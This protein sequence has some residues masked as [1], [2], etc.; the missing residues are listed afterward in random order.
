MTKDG[1]IA[2]MHKQFKI[3]QYQTGET[4]NTIPLETTI[5]MTPEMAA[6][7]TKLKATWEAGDFGHFATY[8]L[9]GEME[10]LSRFKIKPGMH[11]LD[12]ACGAGQTAIPMA[13]AGANVTGIDIASNLIEQARARAKAENVSVRFDEGDAENL[14]YEDNS[15]DVVFSSFGAM[16]APRPDLVAAELKRVCK[17]GGSIIMIN[18]TP[19]GFIGKMFKLSGQHVP[20]SPLMVPPVKWGDEETVRARF[21]DGIAD[22]KL[23]QR[24]FQFQYPFAPADVVEFF[25]EYYG[26]TN[27][28]F[29]ALD[30]GKQSAL[31]SDLEHLWSENNLS[32][33]GKTHVEAEYLEIIATKQ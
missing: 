3:N 1:E 24:L 2:L 19:A 32:E 9:D 20:P 6:L 15:F 16:F 26:P 10:F 23:S 5:E 7:K 30:A 17:P 28:A 14:P 12:V 4:M 11:V 25:R 29:A 33:N 22:L 31:R 27:K 8:M 13:H 18:W 21:A